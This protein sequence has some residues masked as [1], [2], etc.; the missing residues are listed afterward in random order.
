MWR[1]DHV[2]DGL[3]PN[4]LEDDGL[5]ALSQLPG[6]LFPAAADEAAPVVPRRRGQV[7]LHQARDPGDVRRDALPLQGRRER[8]ALPLKPLLR[9]GDL[10]GEVDGWRRGPCR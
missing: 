5:A 1:A 3:P 6:L 4:L 9:C 8:G 7:E 10:A 2:T